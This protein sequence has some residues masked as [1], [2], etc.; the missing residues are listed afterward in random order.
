MKIL[1]KNKVALEKMRM[2]GQLL[3]RVIFYSDFF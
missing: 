3:A 1:V 2:A